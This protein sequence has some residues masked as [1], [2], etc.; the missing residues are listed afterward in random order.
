MY[1]VDGLVGYSGNIITNCAVISGSVSSVQKNGSFSSWNNTF[2]GGIVGKNGSDIYNCFNGATLYAYC[3]R[4]S[5]SVVR[6]RR[7]KWYRSW[8]YL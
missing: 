1:I 2:V 5:M 3:K 8:K 7:N 4:T 6:V